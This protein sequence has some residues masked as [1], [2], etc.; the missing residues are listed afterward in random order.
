[1][2]VCFSRAWASIAG[3]GVMSRAGGR[4]EPDGEGGLSHWCAGKGG[5][6]Q[7]K[8][9]VDDVKW[10]AAAGADYGAIIVR[11][12]S[13]YKDVKE[14]VAALKADPAKV[15]FGAGGSAAPAAAHAGAATC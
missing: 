11:A 9:G 15:V 10:L 5:G 8:Y 7:V 12:D 13:P 3:A 6:G 4:G 14:L 2:G 1:M